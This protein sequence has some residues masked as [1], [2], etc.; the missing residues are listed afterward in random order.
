M[1]R[2]R[3]GDRLLVRASPWE[4]GRLPAEPDSDPEADIDACRRLLADC[5]AD[6]EFVAA[7]WTVSPDTAHALTSGGWPRPARLAMTVSRY[8]LR[9]RSRATPLGELAGVMAGDFGSGGEWSVKAPH[10][11]YVRADSRWAAEVAARWAPGDP[12]ATVWAHPL[13]RRR[14]DRYVTPTSDGREASVSANP[15]VTAVLTSATRPLRRPDLL[16]AVVAA[17]PRVPAE[18]VDKAVAGLVRYGFLLSDT[19]G[20]STD[21]DPL[22]VFRRIPSPDARWDRLAEATETYRAAPPEEAGAARHGM[23]EAM[24]EIHPEAATPQVD[25]VLNGSARLPSGVAEEIGRLVDVLWRLSPAR[26]A[27]AGL[28]RFHSDFLERYGA[29][30]VVPVLTA[31]DPVRGIGPPAGYPGGPRL[32]PAGRDDDAAVARLAWEAVVSGSGEVVLTD[33]DVAGLDEDPGA[34]AWRSLDVTVQVL[35][36]DT[37]AV[38]AGDFL[39]IPAPDALSRRA[40]QVFGRFADHLALTD[41]LRREFAADEREGGVRQV[42]LRYRPNDARIGNVSRVPVLTSHWLSVDDPAAGGLDLSDVGVYAGPDSLHVVLMSTGEEIEPAQL[43][44]ANPVRYAPMPARFL[45]EVELLNSR[46]VTPWRWRGL[47]NLPHLPRVRYGRSVLCPARWLPPPHRD[48]DWIPQWRRRSRVPRHVV[49]YSGHQRLSLDLEHR[50]HRRLLTDELTRRPGGAVFEDLT[51]DG[52]LGWSGGTVH[53]VTAMAFADRDHRRRPRP[54]RPRTAP[55]PT[56]IPPGGDW[57]YLRMYTEAAAVEALLSEVAASL[58]PDFPEWFFVRYP[59]PGHH[60]RVRVHDTPDR[61]GALVSRLPDWTRRAREAGLVG[62]IEIGEYRPET[63]RYGAGP[64]LRAAERVFAADTDLVV[65][66]LSDGTWRSAGVSREVLTAWNCLAVLAALDFDDWDRRLL[67]W[68]PAESRRHVP[69]ADLRAVRGLPTGPAAVPRPDP[70]GV[71]GSTAGWSGLASAL[72][73]YRHA[74]E[75]GGGPDPATVSLDLLHMHAN[76]M[77]GPDPAAERRVLSLLRE[78]V[79]GH[80]ARRRS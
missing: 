66:Q 33:S 43:H 63:H 26:S 67:R 73:V 9:A 37:A 7:L 75:E 12:D 20:T 64:A 54:S 31:L 45:S 17:L 14:A 68:I 24:R 18:A 50:W 16:A 13:C 22:A 79:H 70:A 56:P 30:Q 11:R 39:L 35:A 51:A 21:V 49:L 29:G 23:V 71:P 72:V 57:L 6:S 38:E 65:R 25:L 27:A 80:T 19:A 10:R 53:E 48:G 42:Q 78:L 34:P 62:E 52:R 58:L 32:D 40:G 77:L 36:E 28:W 55:V 69:R 47:E 8:L 44:M 1:G 76:R 2:F 74:L 5:A 15:L 41:P 59:S 60:L 3:I 46:A 61:L 4:P